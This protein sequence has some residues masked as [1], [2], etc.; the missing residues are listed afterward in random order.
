MAPNRTAPS[1]EPHPTA[2]APDE[3]AARRPAIEVKNPRERIDVV[4]RFCQE[5]D[6]FVVDWAPPQS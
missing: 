3:P 2:P 1:T 6:P 4:L 5:D